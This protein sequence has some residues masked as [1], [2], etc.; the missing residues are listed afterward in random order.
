MLL[1]RLNSQQLDAYTSL[2]EVKS[3]LRA[4]WQVTNYQNLVHAPNDPSDAKREKDIQAPS[5][6]KHIDNYSSLW[7]IEDVRLM[8]I[9]VIGD[10][11]VE[12]VGDNSGGWAARLGRM[13]GFEVTSFGVGGDNTVDLLQRLSSLGSGADLILVEIGVNDS[14]HRPSLGDSEIPLADF[15]SNVKKIAHDLL[16]KSQRV[17]F[18]G[19]TR[20]DESRTDPY[21]DDKHYRNDLIANYDAELIKLAG[22]GYFEYVPVPN[23]ADDPTLIFDGLHPSSQGH[24]QLLTAVLAFIDGRV[25][26]ANAGT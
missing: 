3:E 1:L 9:E 10:S 5:Y 7:E 25:A 4:T 17:A 21:K 15:T 6:R 11:F 12:G 20:V 22:E 19:L 26:T 23:L 8:K 13:P 24:M 2:A 16:G 14:R 18:L